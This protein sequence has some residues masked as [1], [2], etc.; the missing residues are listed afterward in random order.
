[1]DIQSARLAFARELRF[2]ARI[3]SDRVMRAFATVPRED[4]L[5]ERPWQVYDLQEGVYWPA[6][7]DPGAAYHN[8]LFA[9]DAARGLNN[10]Q[11]EFWARLLDRMEIRPGD[12]ACHI[13]A[14]TGY[15]T[16]IIAELVGPEGSVIAVEIDPALAARAQANLASRRNVQVRAADGAS[17]NSGP[18]D[19]IV[20]NAGATH[21]LP[22]W[23]Q[24]LKP[25][26]RL[27]LPLTVEG[28]PGKVFRIE[29]QENFES[30][31]ATAISGVQIY[32]CAGAR[33]PRGERLLALA[34]ADGGSRFVRSLRLDQHDRDCACWLHG[35]GFCL[36][37]WP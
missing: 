26:G 14:G 29:R 24:S 6:P 7:D 28:R 23:L 37:T 33:T 21:P 18:V 4:F 16:A 19:L 13:G 22:I 8:V 5:G 11:P 27:L 34:L 36:S 1:M 20:V 32:P 9:I 25:G 3:R 35:D 30:F 15:Y 2:V 10:G 31:G 12:R 17:F